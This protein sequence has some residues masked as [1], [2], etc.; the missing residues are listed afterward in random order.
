[1][2]DP[3]DGPDAVIR[4][5]L[6]RIVE[7]SRA[8]LAAFSGASLLLTGAT[9]FLGRY[10]VES[11]V[12]FNEVSPGPACVVTLP[13]RRPDLLRSRY[14]EQV[15][16]GEIVVVEWGDGSA[17]DPPDQGWDYVIHGAAT[18]DPARFREDPVASLR[19]TVGMA[20]SVAEVA[21]TS[22]ASRVALISSGAVYGDQPQG[23]PAIPE[24][25]VAGPMPAV[26][27]RAYAE[28][29]RLSEMFF[30]ITGLDL[31]VARVFSVVGPYQ[32][33]SASFAVPD[34]IR[35]AAGDGILRLTSDGQAR[36]SF[37]YTTD[38]SVILFKLLLGEPHHTVYNVGCREGTASIAEVAHVIAEI[39]GGLEVQVS[40]GAGSPLDYVPALE[41][42][43]EE[44]VPVVG[45]R[46]GLLRTCHSLYARG[47][48]GRKP[49]VELEEPA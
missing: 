17:I 5:D 47:L 33:L 38:L 26:P 15:A 45:L 31:A 14:P 46:E 36:R 7:S 42:L 29:K 4:A 12:R 18:T 48:I 8:E 16:A 1:M 39:F 37:C 34:L 21:K 30:G 9:G 11:V 24:T 41:R 27:A 22:G 20:A 32:D 49:T 19:E 6:D 40:A 25:Y 10:L 13:T 2:P 44:Y 28:A 43:Y 3:L 35:Q 23:L